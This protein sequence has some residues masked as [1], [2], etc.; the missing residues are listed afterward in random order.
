MNEASGFTSLAFLKVA[1][2][3]LTLRGYEFLLT[4]SIVLLRVHAAKVS[5]IMHF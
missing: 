4:T 5:W 1:I 3:D 2:E